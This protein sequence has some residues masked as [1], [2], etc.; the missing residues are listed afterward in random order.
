MS[1]NI[2]DRSFCTF[3]KLADIKL[4][5]KLGDWGGGA[6]GERKNGQFRHHGAS[7]EDLGISQK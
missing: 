5:V 1:M 4:S 2:I 6:G 7:N 3:G